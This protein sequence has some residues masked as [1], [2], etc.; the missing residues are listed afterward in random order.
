MKL[1]SVSQG[2]ARIVMITNDNYADI[3]WE[4]AD[5]NPLH[6][7]HLSIPLN[8]IPTHKRRIGTRIF[9]KYTF[10]WLD[11]EDTADDIR[12]IQ[13]R[14]F[15]VYDIDEIVPSLLEKC[16]EKVLRSY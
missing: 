10:Y 6:A 8:K 9:V 4:N 16:K 2:Y 15:E 14:Q 7:P 5:G 13:D 11:D 3:R 12:S 1:G